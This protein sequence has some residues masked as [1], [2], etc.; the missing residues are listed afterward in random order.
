MLKWGKDK[1]ILFAFPSLS[2]QFPFTL[3]VINLTNFFLSFFFI[4][5]QIDVFSYFFFFFLHESYPIIHKNLY[6]ASLPNNIAIL[7][8]TPHLYIEI[9]FIL[10]TGV[11]CSVD[12]IV[13][14]TIF[15]G[16]WAFWLF[17]KILQLQIMLQWIA[18]YTCIFILL[19]VYINRINP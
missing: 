18:L 9:V 4:S 11:E 12:S 8:L 5:E 14:L 7:D 3:Q 10:F 1:I 15:L 13:Y 17:S 19:E 6:F 2:T 16:I